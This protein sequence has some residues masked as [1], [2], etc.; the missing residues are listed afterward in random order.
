MKKKEQNYI[1]FNNT[2]T[3]KILQRSK[4]LLDTCKYF[5]IYH[6]YNYRKQLLWTLVNHLQNNCTKIKYREI[7]K[8]TIAVDN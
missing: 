6:K 4:S 1:I 3:Q 7:E 2:I 5:Y 8:N